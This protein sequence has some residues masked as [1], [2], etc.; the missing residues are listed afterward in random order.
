MGMKRVAFL[1]GPAVAGLL[2]AG[3]VGGPLRSPNPSGHAST[4]RDLATG[5]QYP[6]KSA[7]DKQEVDRVFDERY[8]GTMNWLYVWGKDRWFDLLDVVSWDLAA[9]RGFGVNAHLTEYGQA[10]LSWWEGRHFGQR[11]R[12]W[13]VW[14]TESVDR[15]LGPFYW[16]EYER[17][18]VWGTQSL[19]GHEYKFTGWDLLE[20][21]DLKQIHH[22]WSEVGARVNLFAVGAGASA[23]PVEAMDFIVGLN[24]VG[25]VANI[26]GYHHPIWD[27]SGDDTHAEIEKELREEKGLGN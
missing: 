2:L 25:L 12:A 27:V 13:G 20:N 24:P 19:F 5:E 22:D 11:G 8:P 21:G 15:G 9:G 14:D 18:P 17:R 10:G 7:A 23:S 16:L 6:L 3:C 4:H 1:F 26:F